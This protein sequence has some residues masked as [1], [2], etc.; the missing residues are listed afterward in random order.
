MRAAL[1]ARGRRC[2]PPGAPDGS[3]Q[4]SAYAFPTLPFTL[5]FNLGLQRVMPGLGRRMLLEGYWEPSDSQRV[6]WAVGAFLLVRRAA[7]D[8]AGGFDEADWMFA[9]DL[10]LGW[11]LHRAGFETRLVADAVVRHAGAAATGSVWGEERTDRWLESTYRWLVR[12]RGLARTRLTAAINVAGAAARYGGY[13]FGARVLPR[14]YAAVRDASA[15][16]MRRHRRASRSVL[17]PGGS[18]R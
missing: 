15:D 5:V 3:S 1:S 13:S 6:P 10:D 4:H 16:W 9:E 11:R 8:A 17:H 2:A 7:W 18:T 12:R 14:R